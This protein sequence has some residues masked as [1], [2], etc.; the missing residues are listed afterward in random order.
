MHAKSTAEWRG[1]STVRKHHNIR[2]QSLQKQLH[3]NMVISVPSVIH[4]VI[5]FL[6]HP[7]R[8]LANKFIICLT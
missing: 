4:N 2:L 5:F 7:A 6:T 3:M 1:D 8:A